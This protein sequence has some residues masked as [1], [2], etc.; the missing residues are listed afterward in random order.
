MESDSVFGEASKKRRKSLKNKKRVNKHNTHE[1]QNDCDDIP[2]ISE[3]KDGIFHLMQIIS[4]KE[5]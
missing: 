4:F 1:N 2:L 5:I 3:I